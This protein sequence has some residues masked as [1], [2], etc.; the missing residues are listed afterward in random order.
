MYVQVLYIHIYV[1][2]TTC[3]QSQWVLRSEGRQVTLTAL[4][5]LLKLTGRWYGYNI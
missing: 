5:K 3:M 1:T 2:V 4:L